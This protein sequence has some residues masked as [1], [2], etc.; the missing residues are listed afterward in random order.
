MDKLGDTIQRSET[1]L[2]T[3]T[4]KIKKSLSSP[5]EPKTKEESA[6]SGLEDALQM[7]FLTWL[8]Q[9]RPDRKARQ[10]ALA[11]YLINPTPAN[12]GK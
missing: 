1:D 8:R 7:I 9:S 2:E 10:I 6:F 11:E 12:Y 4:R 3:T 5:P